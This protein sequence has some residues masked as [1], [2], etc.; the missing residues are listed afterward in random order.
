MM[1]KCGHKVYYLVILEKKIKNQVTSKHIKKYN[2]DLVWLYSPYYL[3]YKVI[4]DEAISYLKSKKI[5]IVLYGTVLPIESWTEQF[6]FW[7]KID[8]LFIHDK[9]L[10]KFLKRKKLN[11]Y[12]VP[13]GFYPNQYYKIIS[14][15]KKWD[16]SFMGTAQT[17]VSVK[18][19]KRVKYLNAL[20]SFNIGIYGESFKNR[21]SKIKI[22]SFR[23]HEIQRK[24]YGKTKINL[25]LPFDNCKNL[26]YK[27]YYY[28][29]NRFFE[30]PATGNFLLT[31]RCPEF[32]EI[33]GEDTIGYYDDNIESLK[34]SV[35]K[36]LKDEELRKKMARKSYKLVHE[37]YT[38]LHR[39][40]EMFVIIEK[41]L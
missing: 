8:F 37:K 9:N 16:I 22:M 34:E 23:G 25:D 21:I 2:P 19:D 15:K 27:K 14:P 20:S 17:A 39:F 11:T 10:Y 33:F 1:E 31:A 26:F 32:L 28:F 12:Y 41:F 6:W 18:N 7:K 13:L 5:P 29:K 35:K 36:Y 30:I 3:S 40:K 24:I 4:S 38:F